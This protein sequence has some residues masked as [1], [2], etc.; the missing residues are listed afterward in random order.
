MWPQ[1]E[2]ERWLTHANRLE[3]NTKNLEFNFTH[4]CQSGGEIKVEGRVFHGT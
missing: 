4:N 3:K 2:P 1:V